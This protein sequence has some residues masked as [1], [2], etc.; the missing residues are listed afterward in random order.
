MVHFV[1]VAKPSR[2]E[3]GKGAEPHNHGAG[4]R[5]FIDFNVYSP[6]VL[7]AIT[8]RPDAPAY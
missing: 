5:A 6:D 3:V 7:P 4:G 2:S 1:V 8:P